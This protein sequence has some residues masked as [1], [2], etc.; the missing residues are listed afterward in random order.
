MSINNKWVKLIYMLKIKYNKEHTEV[1][2]MEEIIEPIIFL[3]NK[4]GPRQ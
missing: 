4:K 2:T 1:I 3:K